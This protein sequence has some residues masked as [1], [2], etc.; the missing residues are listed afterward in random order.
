[1]EKTLKPEDSLSVIAEMV[2]KT[3]RNL[4]EGSFYYLMWG[5]LALGAAGVEYFLLTYMKSDWHPIVWPVMGVLGGIASA[6]YSR[7]AHARQGHTSFIES[8]MKIVWMA[9]G[10]MMVLAIL[11]GAT[12]NWSLAYVLII[13][14]YGMGTFISGGILKFR[15]LIYGGVACWIISAV[16]ILWSSEFL[17]F[18]TMLIMLMISLAVGYLIPGYALKNS[19]A[20]NNAA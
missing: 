9:F 16:C 6:V 5:W 8:A 14:L 12:Q 18:P 3:K 11:M 7:K 13:A 1:M 15:P 19:E 10:A 4:Q 2:S 20:K 17:H